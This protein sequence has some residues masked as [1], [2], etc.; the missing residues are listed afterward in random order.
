MKIRAC[1][2]GHKGATHEGYD[3]RQP[4]SGLLLTCLTSRPVLIAHPISGKPHLQGSMEDLVLKEMVAYNQLYLQGNL[5]I[6]LQ[7]TLSLLE[8]GAHRCNCFL[9]SLNTS[10]MSEIYKAGRPRALNALPS[11]T[12]PAS[13]PLYFVTSVPTTILSSDHLFILHR[14]ILERNCESSDSSRIQPQ[15]WMK[16]PSSISITPSK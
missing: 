4:S 1:Y 5:H 16:T 7:G 6:R 15:K 14:S 8:S 9:S 12:S 10:R 11:I 3:F 2:R 13:T